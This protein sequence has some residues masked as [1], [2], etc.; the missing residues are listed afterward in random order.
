MGSTLECFVKRDIGPDDSKGGGGVLKPRDGHAEPD[1]VEWLLAGVFDRMRVAVTSQCRRDC[2]QAFPNFRT[3]QAGVA[4][5]FD[6]TGS[7]VGVDEPPV[8]I[9]LGVG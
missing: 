5:Q 4:A 3:Y 9:N 7:L 6:E 1:F 8:R 2:R